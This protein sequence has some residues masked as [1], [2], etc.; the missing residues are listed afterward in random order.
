MF[1]GERPQQNSIKVTVDRGIFKD[2]EVFGIGMIAGDDTGSLLQ[3]KLKLFKNVV[4]SEVVEIKVI[5]E[6]LSW[7]VYMKWPGVILESDCLIVV[8]DSL[9]LVMICPR[10]FVKL[11]P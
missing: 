9:P 2:Q 10:S 4:E 7:L 11:T 5:K 8:L 6:A 1:L 3:A